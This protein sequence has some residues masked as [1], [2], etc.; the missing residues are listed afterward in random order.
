MMF[1]MNNKGEFALSD[2][3]IYY[4][5]TVMTQVHIGRKNII[6]EKKMTE[7]RSGIECNA[8]WK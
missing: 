2:F 1:K 6:E 7:Y 5:T 8:Y 3:K 4:E